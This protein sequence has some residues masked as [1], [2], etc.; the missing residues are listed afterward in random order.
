MT[1]DALRRRLAATPFVPFAVVTLSGE[2][3]PVRN[4]AHCEL[5]GRRVRVAVSVRGDGPPERWRAV[6]LS[7]V[8]DSEPLSVPAPPASGR[9][10]RWRRTA[11]IELP[12]G[13]LPNVPP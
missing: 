9:P 5:I 2:R 6:V 4:P 7:R 12:A 8:V 11:W 3:L 1:A 10:S 13:D